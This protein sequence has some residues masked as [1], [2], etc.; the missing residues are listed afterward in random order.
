M[1]NVLFDKKFIKVKECQ[2]TPYF[3]S[4]RLGMDSVAFVLYDRNADM[5]GLINERKPPM[6]ERLRNEPSVVHDFQYEQTDNGYIAFLSTAFGGSNDGID[7]KDYKKMRDEDKIIH[8]KEIVKKEV[9][10]ES[11]YKVDIND[12]KFVTRSF[13][14]T[15]QNQ[16]CFLFIVDVTDKEAGDPQFEN[17]TEAMSIVHWVTKEFI[18]ENIIDWKI[19]TILFHMENGFF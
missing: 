17:E 11:G 8:F 19:K 9:I 15:Q 1:D 3:Y 10:E 4:E 13:V 18:L 5:Y 2:N 14:S 16:I 12:I 6:D 7:M